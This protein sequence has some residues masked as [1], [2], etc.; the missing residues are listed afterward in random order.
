MSFLELDLFSHSTTLSVTLLDKQKVLTQRWKLLSFL[1]KVEEA[2][3][4][5]K[6]KKRLLQILEISDL[7]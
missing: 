6:L 5:R 7:Q 1:L 2:K 3:D 4:V